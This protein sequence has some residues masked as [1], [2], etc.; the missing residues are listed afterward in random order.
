MNKKSFTPLNTFLL[1]ILVHN[2]FISAS[3]LTMKLIL[4]IFL[5]INKDKNI[6]SLFLYKYTTDVFK[7][8][9]KM[10]T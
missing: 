8:G 2:H 6:S 3:P 1:N 9:I 5:H 4:S 7:I 10:K